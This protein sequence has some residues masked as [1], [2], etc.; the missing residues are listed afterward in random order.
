VDQE[1]AE[2]LGADAHQICPY[3]KATCGNTEVTID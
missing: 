2:E 3:S 1:T